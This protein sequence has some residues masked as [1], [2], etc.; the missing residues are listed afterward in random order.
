MGQRRNKAE[1]RHVSL[2]SIICPHYT[3]RNPVSPALRGGHWSSFPPLFPHFT[4]IVLH[5][6]ILHL[7]SSEE[8]GKALKSF[9]SSQRGKIQ[10][11]GAEQGCVCV[12]VCVCVR[13]HTCAQSLSHIWLFVTPW[14]VAHQ[15]PLSMGFPSQEYWIGLPFPSPG[16]LPDPG[17]KSTS[18]PLA[19]GFFT[20]EPPGIVIQNVGLPPT[21]HP[22]SRHSHE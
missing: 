3:T 5:N 6:V 20:T 12:C 16:D 13:A 19:E 1:F 21:P 10:W 8:S 2:R 14:I 18:P 4:V 7:H 17:I 9:G 11:R 15:A 22:P